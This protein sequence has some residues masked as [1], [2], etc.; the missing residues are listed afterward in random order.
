MALGRDVRCIKDGQA[1]SIPNPL[2]SPHS[3]HWQTWVSLA[4]QCLSLQPC[5]T[6]YQPGWEW[7]WSSG[8]LVR[9]K[10]LVWTFLFSILSGTNQ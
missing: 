1:Q 4:K 8:W 5:S 10:D 3:S 2:A 9:K 6:W 7:G